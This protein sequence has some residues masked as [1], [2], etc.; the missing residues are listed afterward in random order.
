MF[1]CQIL[2]FIDFIGKFKPKYYFI[3]NTLILSEIP[4]HKLVLKKSVPIIF[5]QNLNSIE[6]LYNGTK[7][8]VR[9][10]NKHVI[11]VEILTGSHLEKKVFIPQIS[12]I[13]S[14]TE[15][16]FKLIHY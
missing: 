7:L 12:I 13:S 16:P 1:D 6:R 2:Y 14:D 10:F 11:D 4:F 8:I 3:L 5:L 9:E 15:L